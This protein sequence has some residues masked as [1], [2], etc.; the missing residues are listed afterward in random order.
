MSRNI[1]TNLIGPNSITD[2]NSFM[3][4]FAFQTEVMKSKKA[5]D[6]KKYK[7]LNQSKKNGKGK[8]IEEINLKMIKGLNKSLKNKSTS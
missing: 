8:L 3:K 1:A 5:K 2:K 6:D 7:E 4:Q